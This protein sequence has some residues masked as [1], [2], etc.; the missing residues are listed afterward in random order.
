MLRPK[1]ALEQYLER[2]FI[3]IVPE[4]KKLK[5]ICDYNQV[6][7]NIP[8]SLTSDYLSFRRTLTEAN[9]FILFCLLTAYEQVNES[10]NSV[11]NEYYNE[12]EVKTYSRLQY[13][14]DKIQFPLKFKA[15]QVE[16]DQWMTTIDFKTLM[17]YRAEQLI[18][19]DEITQRKKKRIVRG[20]NE[21]FVINKNDTSIYE[22]AELYKKGIYIPTPFTFNIPLDTDFS[23]HYDE[24]TCELIIYSLENFDIVDGYHRYLAAC[25]VCD[26]MEDFVYKMELRII[27][28]ST[29]KAQQFIFQEEQKNFM[30]KKDSNTYDQTNIA[31]RVVDELNNSPK[32]NLQGLLSRNKTII[33]YADLSNSIKFFYL[34]GFK[35]IKNSLFI[36]VKNELIE[37]FNMLTEYNTIFLEEKM[38]FK[39]L[40]SIMYCFK[41]YQDKDKTAMCSTI[42]NVLEKMKTVSDVK[43]QKKT[44]KKTIIKELDEILK[45]VL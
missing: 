24:D 39:N 5:E 37:N 25:K 8:K 19:Y 9:D 7:H 4:T 11:I 18:V 2:E 3:D 22:I 33:D 45:G 34:T 32:S 16:K 12:K 20:D 40:V 6:I 36:S 13:E 30:L 27:N 35:E 43:Y 44:I 26:E 38:S 31:N 28:F 10:K 42:M 17:M 21:I 14:I 23:Y 29:E 15:I 1:E 41:H